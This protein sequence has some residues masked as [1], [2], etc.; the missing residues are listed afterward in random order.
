MCNPNFWI[1]MILMNIEPTGGAVGLLVPWVS[2]AG[3][4][5]GFLLSVLLSCWVAGGG[6]VYRGQG[7]TS[8]TSPLTPN[9]TSACPHTWTR[10]CT[11]LFQGAAAALWSC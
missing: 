2:P 5:T 10:C 4:T 9:N 11:N 8:S 7:Y 6:T 3:V 1:L